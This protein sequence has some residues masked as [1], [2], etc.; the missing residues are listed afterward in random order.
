MGFEILIGR[1]LPN[2][3]SIYFQN[4]IQIILFF[5]HN[6]YMLS[7]ITKKIFRNFSNQI[8]PKPPKLLPG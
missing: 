1:Y 4:T 3:K 5:I 2:Y 7:N 8:I 6:Y